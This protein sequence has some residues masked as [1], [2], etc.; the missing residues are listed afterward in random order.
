MVNK[1]KL[2]C[3]Y[4]VDEIHSNNDV[5]SGEEINKRYKYYLEN[6]T[7]LDRKYSKLTVRGLVDEKE[8]D[9]N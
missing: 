2:L 4:L 3:L 5:L 6:K 8:K 9:S 1:N 7:E